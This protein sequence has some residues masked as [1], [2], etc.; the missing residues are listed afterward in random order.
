VSE[1]GGQWI[2]P[3]QTAVADLARELEIGTFETYYQGETVYLAGQGRVAQDLHGT[4]GA[5][6]KVAAQLNELARTVP[7]GAPWKSA[8]CSELDPMSLGDWLSKQNLAPVDQVGW[9]TSSFL[10]GGAMPA[11]MGFLHFLSMINSASS[12]YEQLDSIKNSAQETRFVGGSQILCLTMH[13]DLRDKVRLST[14]VRQIRDW[15]QAI[16]SLH[17]DQGV[18]RAR[19]VV[20]ALSPPLCNQIHFDPPLPAARAELHRRWPAHSPGRKT[21]HVYSTP[22]W[23]MKGLSGSII[24][25]NGPLFWAY[26]NSPPDGSIGV[27]NAFVAQSMVPSDPKFA[28]PLLSAIYAQALGEEAL[29]PVQ[30]HDL[31]WG[32]EPWTISCVSAIPPGFWSRHGE[33]LHPAVGNLIWSGTETADIW[34]GYM[35]GAVRS[36]HRAALQALQALRQA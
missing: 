23:R 3:G 19:R 6:L 26:D 25:A 22:F 33:A 20:M 14:P 5:D 8:R 24:Q 29:Q 12:S 28:A 15:N 27:I 34:A 18:V 13:G 11:K 35:D 30:F 31:D 4:F 2:G 7:S 16:V 21:A 10:S 1:A 9:T 32:Q 36:G 17:T